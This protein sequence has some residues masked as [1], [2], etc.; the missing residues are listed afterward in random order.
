[1]TLRDQLYLPI[2]LLASSLLGLIVGLLATTLSTDVIAA[3]FGGLILLCKFLLPAI[4]RS[5][6]ILA[7]S[8]DLRLRLQWFLCQQEIIGSIPA[9]TRTVQGVSLTESR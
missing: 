9:N 4:S 1:M 8:G 3:A 5:S 6:S 7:Y 2:G